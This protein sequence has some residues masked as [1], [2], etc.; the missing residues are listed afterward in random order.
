METFF[1]RVLAAATMMASVAG[2]RAAARPPVSQP[3]QPATSPTLPRPD[4][5]PSALPRARSGYTAADVAFVQGMIHHHAQ[6]LAMTSLVPARTSREDMRLLA[7]RIEVSQKDE[8]AAMQR[9]L[10]SRGETAPDPD[11]MHVQHGAGSSPHMPGML[12]P[13]EMTQLASAKGMAF[14]QAFLTFMIRHHEGALT[15]VKEL[16]ATP[17]A[18]QDAQLFEFASE[19]DADQRAEIARIR[20]LLAKIREGAR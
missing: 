19:V 15:M 17:G 13:E 5:S 10:A 6:A 3:A 1:A 20:A 8:I 12:T 4:T 9:W 16:F 2:C 18:A 11:P 7:E 14:D